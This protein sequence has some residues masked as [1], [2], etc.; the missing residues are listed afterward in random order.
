M[1]STWQSWLFALLITF[2]LGFGSGY[3]LHWALSTPPV[4]PTALL[5]A[6]SGGANSPDDANN[7]AESTGP[8]SAPVPSS[9]GM[10]L[11]VAV[12]G[13]WLNDTTRTLLQ[14]IQPGGVVLRAQNLRSAAQ[15]LNL[16]R[17]IKETRAEGAHRFSDLPF[18][19]LAPDVDAAAALGIAD[20]NRPRLVRAA[21]TS[22]ARQLGRQIAL[23]AADRGINLLLGPILEVHVRNTDYPEI[24]NAAYDTDP[25]VVASYG[26]EEA[27]GML[28]AGV[29]A[30]PAYFPGYASAKR[31]TADALPVLHQDYA[32]LAQRMF[33]FNEAVSAGVHGLVVAH[34][35]VP[36]LEPEAPVRPAS[37]S[38]KVLGEIIRGLWG[39]DGVLLADDISGARANLADPEAAAVA[40]LA[41][42][43]DA[44]LMLDPNPERIRSVARAV[45][46]ALKSGHVNAANLKKSRDRFVRWQQW[47][48]GP[49]S[50]GVNHPESTTQVARTTPNLPDDVK[51]TT[52][53]LDGAGWEPADP[54]LSPEPG[55]S[56]WPDEDPVWGEPA[57]A[58]A[59][60][61]PAESPVTDPIDPQLGPTDVALLPPAEPS[62]ATPP[63]MDSTVAETDEMEAPEAS[64]EA[65]IS[66]PVESD[67]TPVATESATEVAS[68]E[69]GAAPDGASTEP[70]DEMEPPADY[71]E[72]DQGSADPADSTDN[73]TPESGPELRVVFH[74]VQPGENLAAI[75][76]RYDVDAAALKEW[77]KLNGDS[78]DV[79]QSLD[80][81]LSPERAG[82]VL[83]ERERSPLPEYKALAYKVEEGDTLTEIA[84]DHGVAVDDIVTW[85]ELS[86]LEVR[87]GRTLTIY[88]RADAPP[89]AEQ[90]PAPPVEEPA[91]PPADADQDE[92]TPPAEVPSAP[93]PAVATTYI[94]QAG[95]TLTRI[96]GRHGVTPDAVMKFNNI[97]NPNHIFVG[98]K[99]KIPE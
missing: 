27:A 89:V 51:E 66:T 93:A 61:L 32:G 54:A 13:H 75:A 20:V 41:A 28:D 74:P 19:A 59:A 78:L 1:K 94:V 65:D 52:P 50:G 17:E 48:D 73:D 53:M 37:Q 71:E 80:V 25:V 11:F 63:V 6:D 99:L 4:V 56:P 58:P 49:L 86:D 55:Y 36:T 67:V 45:Q 64:V 95:D 70:A 10:H 31:S 79:G 57:L 38:P 62:L 76:K 12:D 81:P 29:L 90:P 83:A 34:V 82:E 88:R 14:E 68:E 30:A 18:I 24:A 9:A 26:L 47:L 91:A 3:S 33:P 23:A 77:N 72:S 96:S 92:S 42:G 87:S 8:I 43:C 5:H 46:T 35:S 7:L 21:E 60:Q 98:Q 16:V 2:T 22:G 44:V 69:A 39:F 84:R 40:S 15:I 97:S 85:N